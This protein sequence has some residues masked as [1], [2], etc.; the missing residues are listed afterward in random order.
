MGITISYRGSLGDLD[1]VEDFEDRALDLALELGGQARIWRTSS[2]DDPR[3][4]VRGVVLNLYPGQETTSLLIAPEG[5]LIN[6]C[7]IE[8]AEKG[9]LAGPPW[10]FVKT[11][12][13]PIEGHVALVEMLAALKQEFLPDLEVRDEGEYWETRDLARL[14]AKIGY[15]QAAIDGLAEGLNRYGLNHEAAE[16]QE[17]LVARIERI[18]RLVQRT[19]GRPAEHPPVR[20]D[21]EETAFGDDADG[22]E[23]QWDA[24]Y[25]ENR[26]RQEHVHRAIEEHLA[27][28][29]DIEDAFDAAMLEETAL[30]LPDESPALEPS[31]HWTEALEAEDDEPWR[32]SPPSPPGDNDGHE[33]FA[34]RRHHPLQQ[35]ALDLMLRLH[36]LLG[37]ETEAAGS[38]PDILL[39]GA[40][41]MLGGLAQALGGPSQFSSDGAPTEGWSGTVPFSESDFQPAPGLSVVQ[42]KRALRGA[43]F[44][45]GALFPLRANGALDQAAFDELHNTIRDLQTDVFAE[46]SRLRQRREDEC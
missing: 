33:D 12:F 4:M 42:L 10:C 46:L 14:T 9:Q 16:D 44:A 31:D 23:S 37:S 19:L 7:E 34:E 18:A 3:R 8:E 11:Q 45:L 32:E 15:V 40:G 20:W 27:R 1:R 17:I 13:G 41:D 5:W 39:Q 30:G 25:K 43:A 26:R 2:D 36:K 21:D 28:G 29:D 24:S 38:H 22:S 35:R 6:L